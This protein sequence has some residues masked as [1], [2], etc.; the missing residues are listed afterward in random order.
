MSLHAPE[1]GVSAFLRW[2]KRF[3]AYLSCIA[4]EPETKSVLEVFV[5]CCVNLH[6][7]CRPMQPSSS[8][9]QIP[10]KNSGLF[11]QRPHVNESSQLTKER[12]VSSYW[13][14]TNIHQLCSLRHGSDVEL[15]G[16]KRLS[17]LRRAVRATSFPPGA[18]FSLNLRINQSEWTVSPPLWLP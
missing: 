12:G 16:C 2:K 17:P 11:P 7:S 5:C 4:G 15:G 10:E 18:T 3:C 14:P 9:F 6:A 13:F 1:G 8:W